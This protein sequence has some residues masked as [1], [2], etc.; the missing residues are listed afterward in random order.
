ME[1]DIQKWLK[2][3]GEAFLRD[4]G[5][6]RGQVILDFGCGSG[7]YTIPAAKTV[8]KEGKVYAL[9]KDKGALAQLMQKAESEDTENIVPIETSGELK[10]NL[11]NESVEAVFLYNTLHYMTVDERR[12]LYNEVHRILKSGG[13]LLVYP[14]HLK[15]DEPL[16]SLSNMKLED[17]IEELERAN[18]YLDRKSFKTLIHNNSYNKGFILHFRKRRHP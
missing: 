18:F 17:V 16:W 12:K 14:K 10:I 3:D 6:K 8:G 4:I 2:G 1:S 9:D 15:P 11:E 7:H 13:M 5:I